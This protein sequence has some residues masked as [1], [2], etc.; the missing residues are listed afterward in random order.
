VQSTEVL[1]GL[2]A[3]ARIERLICRSAVTRES[4]V[5][6]GL[7]LAG[8]RAA[9]LADGAPAG[10]GD[11]VVAPGASCVHHV[12]GA[13]GHEH[14][15]AFELAA[16]SVQ[17]A[18][19]HCLAAHLLSQRL[20]RVGLCSLSPA[21]AER[22]DVVTLPGAALAGALLGSGT[23]TAE[24]DAEPE[25]ILELARMAL[26]A[27]SERT[28]G[29]AELVEY[30][31][32]D[33]AEVVLVASG[34]EAATAGEVARALSQGGVAAGALSVVLVRPFP[35]SA[36][37]EVVAGAQR[38]FVLGEPARRAALLAQVRVVAGEESEI[39]S[40]PAGTPAQV[41]EALVAHLREG[42]FDLKRHVPV[43]DAPSRRLV[44]APPGP[45]GEE[46]VRR[47]GAALAQLG[48]MRLGPRTRSEAGATV[49][50]WDS[51][52]APKA[53]GDLLLAAEPS[54]LDP[55]AALSLI[56]PGSTALVVSEADTPELLARA[57]SPESRS[58]ILE[59][60]LALHWVAPP[61][62]DEGDDPRGETDGRAASL[63]LAGASL[64]ALLGP[65]G[66]QA[67]EAAG[68]AGE[69]RWLRAGA[70]A[71]R[72]LDPETLDP[73]RHVQELDFRPAPSL[74]RMPTREDDAEQRARWAER[75]WRF[76]LT[77]G[78]PS[79][80]PGLPLRTAVLWNLAQGL[81]GESPHPFV[82]VRSDDAERPI[83][84]RRLRG[85]LGEAI[86]VL[87]GAGRAARA[88]ADNLDRLVTLAA[89]ELAEGDA[90]V[91]LEGLL[92]G[93]GEGLA[94]ELALPEEEAHTLADD[95][96]ELRRVLPRDAAVLDL[97]AEMPM[98]LYLKVLDA[99]RAP[100]QQRFAEELGDLCERLRD[101]LQ[102]DQMASSEGRAPEVL[103]AALGSAASDYID[104]AALS[105]TLPAGTRAAALGEQRRR[106][107]QWALATL[108]THLEQWA[109]LPRVI[110]LR[111]PSADLAVPGVEQHEHP[112]PLAAAVGLFD[113]VSRRMAEVFGAARTAR[114]E[115]A[116]RYRPELHD[117]GLAELDW[118]AF[119]GEELD[120]VPTVVVV[121][122]GRR[123]RRRDQISLSELLG[124]SRPVQVVVGD[125][126][127][128]DDGAEDLSRFHV[129][130]GYL[131]VAHREAFAMGS[132]PARPERLVEGLAQMARARRPAVALVQL[133]ALEPAPL[134]PLLAEAALRGRACR[135]FRYDPDAGESWADRFD[136]AG[137]PD[138]ESAWPMHRVPYLE[139]GEEQTLELAF[140]FADAM[141][142]EPAY[143]RHL[144]VVPPVAWDES[145]QPLAEY[146]EHFD[147]EGPQ[148]RVPFLWVIDGDE[149]LQRVIVTREL[150]LA[151][152]DRLRGWRVLQELAGFQ[153][154][155]AERAADAARDQALAEAGERSAEL[156]QAHAAE[157][158]R[159][160]SEAAH[161]SME[162]LAAVL[163]SPDGLPALGAPGAAPTAQPPPA[164]ES[165]ETAAAEPAVAEEIEEEEAVSFD[166]PYIDTPLC[167]SCNECTNLNAQLFHYDGN[168]QAY[169][170]DPAAGTF[171]ELVK[172][173]EL[174]PAHCIHPAKPRDGDSTATPELIERAAKFN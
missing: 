172:A 34:A 167:T 117:T 20:G 96:G 162:R 58:A 25:R 21:L 30:R 39:R 36:V 169:I 49:L 151:S 138:P 91:G 37:R 119:T 95:L 4:A 15:G 135:D 79:P 126:V 48:P 156:E 26:Q 141:A 63:F 86:E 122:S 78:A 50:A 90:E 120:L 7:A 125:Q 101:L 160:R 129:D 128:A 27:V 29:G 83:A 148:R 102:L 16:R 13:P 108:E 112:D 103:S 104:P 114:L 153:N 150:A 55:E 158:E 115:A 19:D 165:L 61:Q 18:V 97:R 45:W 111:P 12:N 69:T 11:A 171:A 157:L 139:D 87:Q 84:A 10:A 154:A 173:A 33:G 124:S 42:S 113:G 166:D 168:K 88:L 80:V 93:A 159:V 146:L 136:L 53:R 74:P 32:D 110:L 43:E 170:A 174:C 106:R 24:P 132:T 66:Q 147:P 3:V 57:L 52:A 94:A 14:A 131:V 140:T 68:A 130:L 82:L 155:F 72:S 127:G 145:Q 100:L 137:N 161:E 75:I 98:R 6:E 81:R 38:V 64:A 56:R 73:A 123:L 70:E 31:G 143:L 67:I 152:R 17:E 46:M 60:D 40:L 54:L 105:Q 92:S 163:I 44:V 71:L 51:E 35:A 134:R 2:E 142:F 23:E 28:Q 65:G 89:R 107:I 59:R 144:L 121:T 8:E 1:S 47:V 133:P 9:S 164:A 76:H 5:A 109:Q 77:G 149:T 22:L 118:E 116:G 62:V 99:V 85:L 41:L